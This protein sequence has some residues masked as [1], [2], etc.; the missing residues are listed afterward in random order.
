MTTIYE[1]ATDG[2][3]VADRAAFMSA[4]RQGLYP[5]VPSELAKAVAAVDGVVELE[6]AVMVAQPEGLGGFCARVAETVLAGQGYPRDFAEKAFAAQQAVDTA[7]AQSV[8][9]QTIRMQLHRR[10]P[11]VITDCLPQMLTGLRGQVH[12]TLT[13]LRRVDAVLGDLDIA[14]PAVVAGA[15]DKQRKALLAFNAQ[16]VSYKLA[17]FAQRSALAASS[18]TPPGW[19]DLMVDH[20]WSRIFATAIHECANVGEYGHPGPHL[21]AAGRFRA[22]AHR[23]DVWVPTLLEL[24]TAYAAHIAPRSANSTQESTT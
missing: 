14:D 16:H 22:L 7:N 12:D 24:D 21:G 3:S 15:S 1:E 20:G 11:G 8:A 9:V 23:P 6:R 2:T 18:A 13:E 19:N 17:R 4:L 10:F 5:V